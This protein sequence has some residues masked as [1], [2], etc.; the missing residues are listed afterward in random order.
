MLWPSER[1]GRLRVIAGVVFF[2][3]LVAAAVGFVARR[4]SSAAV[5]PL[6]LLLIPFHRVVVDAQPLT[7]PDCCTDVLAI[8]D[9]N[10]DS[11]A[12]LVLGA[13]GSSGAGLVWYETPTWQR[14]EI[15][16]GEFTTDGKV[17]DLDQD[18]D[19]DIV[20]GEEKA[21]LTW[22]ENS[23][24][25]SRWLRHQVGAGYVH[26]IEVADLDGS[27]RLDIV[28]CDKSQVVLWSSTASGWTRRQ[29]LAHQGEGIALA[30]MD[31]DS[32][33]DVVFGARWIEN[34]SGGNWPLHII[35]SAWP[36]DTRVWAV[37]M[38]GDARSDVVLTAS[39]GRGRVAWFQ[40]PTAAGG[41]GAWLEHRISEVQLDGAH[42]LV[43][44]DLDG[45][46]DP[47]VAVA[48]MHT[49]R[50][51]RILNFVNEGNDRW[52]V[53]TLATSGS[54]N[55]QAA[56]L[57][58]DGDI[59]LV[60]KNYAGPNRALEYW[61]NLSRDNFGDRSPTSGPFLSRGWRYI[62]IDRRRDDDQR[63]KMGLVTTDV[64]GDDRLDVVGG[65]LLYL[66]PGHDLARAWKRVRV[67]QDADV[68]FAVDADGDPY[69]DLVGT[70]QSALLW[71]ES[72]D[73]TGSMWNER[74]IGR[75]PDARTQGYVAAQVEA[76]GRPELVLT[77]GTVLMYVRIP[78]SPE[79][80]PW[81]LVV[82]SEHAEEEGVA[83]ADVDRDG[84]VDLVATKT[85]G[86]EVLWFENAGSHGGSWQAR[87]IGRGDGDPRWLDRVITA[88]VNQD[89]LV[90]VLVSEETQDWTYNASVY[91]FE[92]P[93]HPRTGVWHRHRIAVLRSANSL[94]VFDTDGDG[95]PDVVTA[96][97]TDMQESDGAPNNLTII[98]E[99]VGEGTRFVAHP[100]ESG[101]HSSHL[102][103]RA[104][105]LD[106]A[107]HPEI[108][109]LGWN[110]FRTLH[111]WW[112]VE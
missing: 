74:A 8:G 69:P 100:I 59:D 13:Q 55:M 67:S 97:H 109:S 42:S 11:R 44:A 87:P 68:L 31:G 5:E 83:A 110:Q 112:R 79:D 24:N 101:S 14:R 78:G 94:D 71:W 23:D 1:T 70:R 66:N 99:N 93:A 61:E 25:G 21:G 41:A 58:S 52:S 95:D 76:G 92:A 19:G 9:I 2:A 40:A 34:T 56:D 26:D 49:S 51:K 28:S 96:E 57:D 43:V 72:T 16:R 3:L 81:P 6:G 36:S 18:G 111:L 45:D 20:I 35:S 107:G 48:E 4:S 88:D 82:V 37:D 39:E 46:R 33:V 77:R 27:G 7:G 91:W 60:G 106:R 65:S 75:V 98:F 63:G 102:G 64:N 17:V 54:H 85:G 86:Q 10:G 89:G 103:A 80:G 90:D 30:D 15:A 50:G 29:L 38:N 62:S 12:D 22:F 108:V 73:S 47:D 104:F 105:D 84:D 53:Q 32:D